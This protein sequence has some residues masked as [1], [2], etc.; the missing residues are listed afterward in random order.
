MIYALDTDD[1]ADNCSRARQVA[2]ELEGVD[3]VMWRHE[4]E[5]IVSSRRG[6]LRFTAGGDLT[7]ARGNRWSVDGDLAVLRA[8]IQDGRILSTEYPDGLDRVW[9]ALHCPTAGDILL[10]AAPGYEF[11]DWGGSDH[12]GGGSHGSLHRSDSLGALVWCG[13]GPDSRAAR[14]QWSLRDI[15]PM[16]RDHFGLPSPAATD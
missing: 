6:E 11:V 16:I 1:P 3:L 15:V 10:S 13:T 2:G 8:E 14:D 9:S 12:V 5:A 4:D 7:D